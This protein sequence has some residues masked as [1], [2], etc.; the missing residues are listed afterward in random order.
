VAK[1]LNTVRRYLRAARAGVQTARAA[2]SELQP[3]LPAGAQCAG[4]QQAGL[5]GRAGKV[6]V[7]NSRQ[8]QSAAT[9]GDRN[10]AGRISNDQRHQQ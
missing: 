3:F 6:E 1:Y 4:P 9:D 8:R 5:S 2:Q 10:L 7:E